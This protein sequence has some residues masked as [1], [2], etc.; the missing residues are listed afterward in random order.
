[1]ARAPSP[2][3][4]RT[5]VRMTSWR[6]RRVLM[7]LA[8]CGNLRAA[9]ELAGVGIGAVYRLR[10]KEPGFAAQ[11]MSARAEASARLAAP[12]GVGEDFAGL[13][14]R[15]GAGGRLRLM[16]PGRPYWEPERH[17]TIFLLALRGT[18]NVSAAAR[19]AGFTRKVAYDQMRARP[20]FAAASLRARADSV[21][22]LNDLLAFQAARW[23][24]AA[25]DEAFE[26]EPLTERDVER[27]IRT[28]DYW[29]R[30]ERRR[31]GGRA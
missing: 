2:A 19:A 18:G 10:R 21:P 27:A 20:A 29:E 6:R 24:R 14:V 3:R 16:A 4:K 25:Y 12:G 28:L 8:E 9:A 22:R 7:L 31:S 17:D 15:R 11:L 13:V 30:A 26:G 1:M 5:Y 23:S